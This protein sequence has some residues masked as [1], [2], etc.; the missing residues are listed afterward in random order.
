MN[1][2]DEDRAMTDAYRKASAR[3][4][5][6][7]ADATRK[8][9]L[10]EAAAAARRRKPA[11]NDL[12][13]LLRG[14]A[15][16]AVLGIAV[17]L[18]QQVDHRMPGD[19]PAVAVTTVLDE[20]K[21]EEAS[22]SVAVPMDTPMTEATPPRAAAEDAARAS[23]AAAAPARA[24]E[25]TEAQSAAPAQAK[26]SADQD[27]ETDAVALLQ[28]HFPQQYQSRTPHRL[29]LVVDATGAVLRSG[30]LTGAQSLADLRQVIEG[31]LGGRLLR[32]W[33]VRTLR[34]ARDQEIELAIAQTP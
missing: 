31:N 25:K 30:E 14:V 9:I 24:E 16:I 19:E 15:G 21:P 12:R 4:A 2:S 32:P 28:R 26:M 17:L 18:W 1:P 22:T 33:R 3:D 10:A 8:A 23:V 29:W 27:A 7:P 13:Y 11:A 34:N 6:G 5:G 20:V